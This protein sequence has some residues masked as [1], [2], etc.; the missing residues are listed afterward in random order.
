ML[1]IIVPLAA[2]L[3][4][5]L[6]LVWLRKMQFDAVHRNL[7]DLVDK[8]GGRVVRSGFA[9]RPRYSGTYKDSNVSISISAEKKN[10]NTPRQFYISVYVQA[11]ANSNFTVISNDWLQW[12]DKSDKKHRFTRAIADKKYLVEVT[13]QALLNRLNYK[14]I[15]HIVNKLHPF[16]YVLV[17]RKGLILERLSSDLIRDTEFAKLESLMEGAYALSEVPAG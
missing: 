15:E 7:L 6:I 14:Q 12:R 2:V 5:I 11:Q 8:Y 10:K 13:N 17:S 16:A 9:V 3:V 1:Y 4:G